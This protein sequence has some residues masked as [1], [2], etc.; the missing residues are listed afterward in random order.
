MISM[1]QEYLADPTAIRWFWL[2][3]GLLVI[4]VATRLLRSALTRRITGADTRYRARKI[5]SGAGYALTLLLFLALFGSQLGA[6]AFGLGAAAAGIAFALQEVIISV[7]GWVALTFGGFYRVGDRVQTS[8]IRGDVIDIGVIRTT[9]MELGEWV[10][11]DQYTG[12]IV[13][14][15]NGSIFKEPVFNYSADFP[16]LWDEI[17]V[18]V[19]YGSNRQLAREIIL[20]V[21]HAIVEKPAADARQQWQELV[22]KYRLEDAST[23]P[24]VTLV[25][26]DNWLE[27]T[28]RYV[29]DYRRRRTTKDQLF[30]LLLDEIDKT[31]KAVEL[32]SATF[33]LVA[34]PRFEMDIAR[35]T[36]RE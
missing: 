33:E 2:A 25:A 9:L 3:F 34:A 15:S 31:G 7:A 36:P 21:A 35:A 20:R 17:T 19:R 23:D 27:F 14:V 12:R 8:G 29:V 16:F 1:L 22:R 30:T 5:A 10:K 11:G 13:R 28:L 24:M 4:I 32:A 26:N 18:P 6:F